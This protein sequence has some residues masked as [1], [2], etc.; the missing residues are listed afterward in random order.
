MANSSNS[1]GDDLK[2]FLQNLQRSE[3]Q[4]IDLDEYLKWD[5]IRF[6]DNVINVAQNHPD[7]VIRNLAMMSLPNMEAFLNLIYSHLN[8]RNST[9]YTSEDKSFLRKI[10]QIIK[11]DNNLSKNMRNS[12]FSSDNILI[13]DKNTNHD[14]QEN[15]LTLT[16]KSYNNKEPIYIK[17]ESGEIFELSE[18]PK[19]SYD[20]NKIETIIDINY[21]YLPILR[22]KSNLSDEFI[23]SRYKTLTEIITESSNKKVKVNMQPLSVHNNIEDEFLKF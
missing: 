13:S 1:C 2:H 23:K 18:H 16:F 8:I 3:I 11:G 21:N 15:T 9:Q 7:E 22:E 20:W 12:K 19:R 5:D 14:G 10:K 17:D 4:D 6:Y